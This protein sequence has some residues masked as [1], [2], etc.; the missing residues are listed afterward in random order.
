MTDPALSHPVRR[1]IEGLDSPRA[2]DLL[3]AGLRESDGNLRIGM[4]G[5][6]GRRQTPAAV[7][8]LAALAGSTDPATA[9]AALRALGA[10]GTVEASSALGELSVTEDLETDRLEALLTVGE[11]LRRT[12]LIEPAKET[13]RLLSA[14][15]F[16]VTIRLGAHLL[17][18]RCM[19]EA[20]AIIARRLLVSDLPEFVAGG[21]GLV[22]KAQPREA[23]VELASL[24]GREGIPT[25]A[26]IDGLVARGDIAARPAILALT[27]GED[28][29][30]RAAA[31]QALGSL[32][33][34]EEVDLLIARLQAGRVEAKAAADALASLPQIEVDIELLRLYRTFEEPPASDLAAILARRSN[35]AAVPFMLEAALREDRIGRESVR[36]LAALSQPTDVPELI[37][38]LDLVPAGFRRGV[39]QAVSAAIKRSEQD[40]PSL[41]PVLGSYAAATQTNKLSLLRIAGAI[42]G[43]GAAERL[44]DTHRN[45]NPEERT[46][47]QEILATTADARYLDLIQ[48]IAAEVEDPL[49]H[50]SL[51][52]SGLR[53]TEQW[54]SWRSEQA[55]P[56]I[57][58]LALL[59]RTVTEKE[60][61]LRAAAERQTPGALAIVESFFDVPELAQ[62]AQI[63]VAALSAALQEASERP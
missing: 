61:V 51:I 20:G 36:A 41:D 28:T 52:R 43:P 56:V 19:P 16:P 7:N 45:G 23:T 3:L 37:A 46:V 9:R 47:V 29:E 4:I 59:A 26:L 57:A 40:P 6:L 55:V 63:A 39:E 21:L 1:I 10:I 60:M 15:A 8:P 31:L 13:A 12:G 38:L 34:P 50:T 35:R 53:L 14:D 42:G 25:T 5:S 49:V 11:N 48:T 54:P 27:N 2:D 22:E 30:T 24:L 44:L 32:G 58:A 33:S 62:E 18:S 17:M